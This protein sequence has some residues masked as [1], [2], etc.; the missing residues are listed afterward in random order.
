MIAQIAGK[1]AEFQERLTGIKE[2][3]QPLT[4][5]QLPTL[6]KSLAR[7]IGAGARARLD[8]THAIEQREGVVPISRELSRRR[9]QRRTNDRHRR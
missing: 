3:R 1:G 2:Q 5:Q 6:H 7:R 4:R 9:V 8:G